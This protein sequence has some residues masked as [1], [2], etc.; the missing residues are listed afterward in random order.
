MVSTQSSARARRP[1]RAMARRGQVVPLESLVLFCGE[2]IRQV[3]VNQVIF[4][5]AHSIQDVRTFEVLGLDRSPLVLGQCAEDV[6][7]KLRLSC[8][9]LIRSPHIGS[10]PDGGVDSDFGGAVVH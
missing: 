9:R 1:A 4:G 8:S 3:V 7:P 10:L 5:A 2:A 6:P